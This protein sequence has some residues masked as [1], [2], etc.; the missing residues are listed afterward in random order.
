[1]AATE[2]RVPITDKAR[3]QTV[4]WSTGCSHSLRNRLEP[5]GK[6]QDAEFFTFAFLLFA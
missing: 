1:M 3:L 5:E 4:T 2:E 6:R